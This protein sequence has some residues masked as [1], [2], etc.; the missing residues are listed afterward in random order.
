MTDSLPHETIN[1]WADDDQGP[2]GA[3]LETET[4]AS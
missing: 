4:C 1:T 3:A 2:V